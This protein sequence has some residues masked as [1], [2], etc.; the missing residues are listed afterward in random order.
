MLRTHQLDDLDIRYTV[1]RVA[2]SRHV[3]VRVQAD[4]TVLACAP[5]WVTVAAIDEVV[6][7]HGAW[8]AKR[9][10]EVAAAP[11]PPTR[12]DYVRYKEAARRLVTLRLAELNAAYDFK[13]A[14]VAIRDT[15]TRWGSCSKG[16]NLNFSY[17]LVLLPP[18]LCDYIIVHELCHLGE[19]NHS[20]RF[21][22]LVARTC[23]HHQRLRRELRK[24]QP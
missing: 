22:A 21:W 15:R 11:P 4:G 19:L 17:R 20:A 5:R 24:W 8:I 9:L 2:R 6:R 3:S 14:R 12:A 10:A 23:P 18:E 7:A 16:G 13:Y 1:R